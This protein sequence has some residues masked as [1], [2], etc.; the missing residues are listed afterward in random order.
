MRLESA[1]VPSLTGSIPERK[2]ELDS[3]L[4]MLTHGETCGPGSTVARPS[5]QLAATPVKSNDTTPRT[6]DSPYAPESHC[7]RSA[8][9]KSDEDEYDTDG[10]SVDLS[11]PML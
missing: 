11:P 10:S 8:A 4:E 5:E 1:S 2:I 6:P 9:L 7:S 3:A